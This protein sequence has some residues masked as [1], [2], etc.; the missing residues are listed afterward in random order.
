MLCTALEKLPSEV[1]AIALPDVWELFE[2]WN[3]WPPAHVLLRGFTGY[4]A[5]SRGQGT[6]EQGTGNR[7]QATELGQLTAML[8]PARKAPA[9]I[10]EM[11]RWG[12]QMKGKIGNA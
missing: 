7:E 5:G 11:V 1:D 8:G 9:Y 6:E 12:E 2:H 3:D 4:G 10:A